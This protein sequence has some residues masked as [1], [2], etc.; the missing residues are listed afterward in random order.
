MQS[1]KKKIQLVLNNKPDQDLADSSLSISRSFDKKIKH[2]ENYS[3]IIENATHNMDTFLKDMTSVY[4]SYDEKL[5]NESQGEE[6][7]ANEADKSRGDKNLNNLSV[8][9]NVEAVG[10]VAEEQHKTVAPVEDSV[11]I[12]STNVLTDDVKSIKSSLYSELSIGKSD[13]NNYLA[14]FDLNS[15]ELQQEIK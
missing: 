11:S 15:K 4:E 1:P 2:L 8:Y 6:E 5:C 7:Y 14:N 3:Q 9:D 13:D 12:Q 10:L